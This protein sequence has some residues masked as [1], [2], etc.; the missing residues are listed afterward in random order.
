MK[1][2]RHLPTKSNSG[3]ALQTPSRPLLAV[4]NEDYPKIRAVED[5]A[6]TDGLMNYLI[7][8][9]NLKISN[10]EEER[11]LNIQMLVVK[12]FIISK[13][14]NL[15]IP[16]I[17]EAFKMYVAREFSNIKTFRLLDSIS[18]G[19]V[20]SAFLD[21][22]NESLRVYDHKMKINAL[23]Q[24]FRN[25][26]EIA[27][28]K[29]LLLKNIFTDVEGKGYSGDAW[30]LYDELYNSGKITISDSE[31]K[32][33]Y[34]KQL[35]KHIKEEKQIVN[36]KR[37]LNYKAVLAEIQKEAMSSKPL[38]VVQNRCKSVLVSEYIKNNFKDKEEF[39][40]SF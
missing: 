15:T 30:M 7:T 23:K 33:L 40:A 13:F 32:D 12:D 31:K 6:E 8:L 36:S 18:A 25:E 3:L 1:T 38:L 39:L 11:D 19:E 27:K 35:Q 20:L 37:P 4:L 5:V 17:K 2:Q 34:K 24:E 22:R 21:H 16:E 10:E 26:D 9:L 29:H 28:T 14:G